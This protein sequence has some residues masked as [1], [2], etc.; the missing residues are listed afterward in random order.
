MVQSSTVC[1]SKWIFVIYLNLCSFNQIFVF[2]NKKTWKELL[3]PFWRNRSGPCTLHQCCFW[4]SFSTDSTNIPANCPCLNLCLKCIS[5]YCMT[6]PA[7][8][9]DDLLHFYC[10][11]TAP[12]SQWMTWNFQNLNQIWANFD[13]WIPFKRFCLTNG[14]IKDGFLKH[15]MYLKMWFLQLWILLLQSTTT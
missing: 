14:I 2:K 15:F 1:S 3:V 8:P 9:M 11:L 4:S 5:T 12:T 6:G 10:I 7:N 13:L